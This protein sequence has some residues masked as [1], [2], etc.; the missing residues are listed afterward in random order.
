MRQFCHMLQRKDSTIASGI[1][2]HISTFF[3]I[4]QVGVK[5]REL[6][7]SEPVIVVNSGRLLEVSLQPDKVCWQLNMSSV[8]LIL[9]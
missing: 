6:L 5:L 2:E 3:R 8:V 9:S 4:R 1:A 7:A